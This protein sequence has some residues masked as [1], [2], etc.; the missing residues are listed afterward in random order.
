MLMIADRNGAEARLRRVRDHVAEL[1]QAG[2]PEDAEAIDFVRE[3]AERVLAERDVS[4]S[5]GLLTTGQAALALGLSDQTVRNWVAAGRLPGVKRGTRTMI[6]R[7]A[8]IAEIERSR[9]QPAE[10]NGSQYETAA[11]VAWRK[12][13]LETLPRR[14]MDR[15]TEL[16]DRFEDGQALS[17]T[18]R[19]E[20]VSLEREMADAAAHHLQKMI[21]RQ[22]AERT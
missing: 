7:E 5:R 12:E 1:R 10:Q 8:V 2:R 17:A 9:V 16:H 4:P 3:L 18:E 19:A 22:R 20:L 14:V 13:L 6:P 11:Q 21:G 15:L